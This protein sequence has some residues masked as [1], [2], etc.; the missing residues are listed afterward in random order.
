VNYHLTTQTGK[1][2]KLSAAEYSL[3]RDY[4]SCR[5][6]VLRKACVTFLG[7]TCLL[8]TNVFAIGDVDTSVLQD[9]SAFYPTVTEPNRDSQTPPQLWVQIELE[10]IDL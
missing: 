4:G 9:E 8:T 7:I 6:E 1:K 3:L 5:N 10:S 2:Y